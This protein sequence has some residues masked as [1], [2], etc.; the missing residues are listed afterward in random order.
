MADDSDD[1][2]LPKLNV[3][4]DDDET[5]SSKE[6]KLY[7]PA[8]LL[9][10]AGRQ[11]PWF[12]VLK[13]ARSAGNRFPLRNQTTIG[14][15]LGNDIE[16]SENGVS[17]RHA[18]A[19]LLPANRVLLED[20]GSSNGIFLKGE[21]KQHVLLSDG[22]R[23][24]VGDAELILLFMQERDDAID[25]RELWV[26]EATGLP[27]RRRVASMLETDTEYADSVDSSL[28]LLLA[29]ID[30]W[31]SVVD[32]DGLSSGNGVFKR[33][34]Q[35][36]QDLARGD[37]MGVGRFAE[38]ILAVILPDTNPEQGARTA[39]WLRRSVHAAFSSP[40]ITLSIGMATWPADG[41]H[42]AATLTENAR[43]SLCRAVLKGRN[44]VDSSAPL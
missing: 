15:A 8:S 11:T 26:D 36:A 4:D 5:T 24:Q 38:N 10:K 2:Q 13:G 3:G 27:S 25:S 21:R 31:F 42:N 1:I 32:R 17:R 14:R 35:I 43:L 29:E 16:L 40:M 19:K 23:V 6:T 18:V 22:D 44:R 7:E 34:A 39:E 41:C 28:S 9:A 20:V 33:V 12:L 30:Q 37:G